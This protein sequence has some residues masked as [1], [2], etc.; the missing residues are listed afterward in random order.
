MDVQLLKEFTRLRLSTFPTQL[1]RISYEI[2]PK[3]IQ[4]EKF[5]FFYRKNSL[6]TYNKYPEFDIDNMAVTF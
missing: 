1:G 4:L 6:K 3:Q 2:N 5:V